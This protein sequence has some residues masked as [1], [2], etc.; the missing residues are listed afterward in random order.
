MRG[1]RSSR[2]LLASAPRRRPLIRP[3]LVLVALLAVGGRLV[4]TSAPHHDTRSVVAVAHSAAAKATHHPVARPSAIAHPSAVAAVRTLPPIKVLSFSGS[5]LRAHPIAQTPAI[6]GRAAIVVDVGSGQ[7]LYSQ[8]ASSRYPEA[9]LTKLMTA[10]VALDL[11]RPD[12]VLT[13]TPGATQV[14]PNHMGISSGEQLSLREL[15]DGM[16]LDS[17]NDAAEAL[18]QGIVG[19]DKFIAFMNQKASGMHLKDTQFANPSGLDDPSHYSSAYDL[20][21]MLASVL[22][23]Y[24]D[25]SAVL[26]TRSISIPAT[27]QHKAFRPYNLD[28]LLWSYPGTIGGKPGYTDAAGYCL[29]VAAS[30]GGRTIVAVVLGTNQHFTDGARLL[31]FGFAHPVTR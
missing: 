8:N 15:L 17:G 20:A 11:A 27:P 26:G 1:T 3:A 6:N 16:L 10:M 2:R 25:V 31:D 19:R 4:L 18:A 24:P 13:V 29:A 30:R 7:I 23:D 12:Q 28:R 5:W 21:V 9:S 22:R 14:E